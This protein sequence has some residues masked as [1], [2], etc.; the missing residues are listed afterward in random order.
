MDVE[1]EGTHLEPEPTKAEES[2]PAEP[3]KPH[4]AVVCLGIPVLHAPGD[5]RDTGGA[6]G[7][8]G[9]G[10]RC[11]D[12]TT[13]GGCGGAEVEGRRWCGGLGTVRGTWGLA[14]RGSK[15]EVRARGAW[16]L[17]ALVAASTCLPRHTPPPC[18]SRAL[19]QATAGVGTALIWYLI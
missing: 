1:P 8:G 5:Q 16:G 12:R 15:D 19:V 18:I 3:P 14:V 7:G 4:V 6:G 13:W 2:G 11:S 17:P 10:E 9:S